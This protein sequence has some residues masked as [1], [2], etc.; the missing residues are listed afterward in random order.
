MRVQVFRDTG[1]RDCGFQPGSRSNHEKD[2]YSGENQYSVHEISV[3][4]MVSVYVSIEFIIEY[5]A[6]AGSYER[7]IGVT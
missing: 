1:S 2:Q 4:R 6:F 3:D 5:R 7:R